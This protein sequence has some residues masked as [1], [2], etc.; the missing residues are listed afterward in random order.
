[1]DRP[2]ILFG[3]FDRHNFGDLLL[4]QVAAAAG[5]LNAGTSANGRTMAATAAASSGFLGNFP[6]FFIMVR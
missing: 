1:M 5:T 2:L 4:A 6:A 3:A